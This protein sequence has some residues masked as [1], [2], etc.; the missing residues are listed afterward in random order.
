M[1]IFLYKLL[2]IIIGQI[3]RPKKM[4]MDNIVTFVKSKD[5]S[6]Y[7]KSYIYEYSYKYL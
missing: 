3:L 1:S 7:S 5:F 6:L 2:H 4:F